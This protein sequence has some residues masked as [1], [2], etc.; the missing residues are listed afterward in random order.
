[1]FKRI[2]ESTT[3]HPQKVAHFGIYAH[4]PFCV[5]RC[6]YCEFYSHT[7][8]QKNDFGPYLQALISEASKMHSWLEGYK[9]PI[10]PTETLFLGGGTPSLI[11]PHLLNSFVA[12][13]LAIYGAA[14]GVEVTLEVNPESVYDGF[15]EG[16]LEG[17]FNRVSLGV[18]SFQTKH[19]KTLERLA[20][21]E[22]VFKAARMLKR[23]GLTNWS[24]DLIFGIP[25]QTLNDFKED[26]KI[27]VNLGS[28]HMSFYHLT[29]KNAHPLF[30]EL[31]GEELTL[32]MYDW[33]VDYLKSQGLDQ[34]EISNFAQPGYECRHNL[35]Y[36]TG[37]DFLGLGPSAASRFFVQGKYFHRKRESHLAKYLKTPFLDEPFTQ[38]SASQSIL[39]SVFL[40]LRSKFGIS[41]KDFSERFG[42]QIERA[43]KFPLF[44]E[45]GLIEE[46]EGIL[47]LTRDGQRLADSI[48]SELV[49]L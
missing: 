31:P 16:L 40:E 27:A 11:E 24:L 14:E 25:G 15:F 21:P 39:E 4:I 19:L 7:E 45:Q 10:S 35:L 37:G 9:K 23:A 8:Y 30:Q 26:L 32:D 44:V 12:S 33:G 20:V 47:Y 49:D 29:L 22:N 28:T 34:Y 13:L 18:Q 43:R 2:S 46:K 5:H 1:M 38:S 3:R 48:A 41:L 6:S 42:Y 17:S 36:W